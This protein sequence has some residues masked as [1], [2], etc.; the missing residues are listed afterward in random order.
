MADVDSLSIEIEANAKQAA[1]NLD[2]LT[3]SVK[4][5]SNAMSGNSLNNLDKLSSSL[6]SISAIGNNLNG[7]KNFANAMNRLAKSTKDIDTTGLGKMMS[8]VDKLGNSLSKVNVSGAARL[9]GALARLG[10]AGEKVELTNKS[11]PQLTNTIKNFATAMARTEQIS[12]EVVQLTSALAKLASAGA[13]AQQ[14]AASLDTLGKEVESVI[15]RLSKAPQVSANTSQ[16][17]YGLGNLASAGASGRKAL[18][19]LYGSSGRSSSMLSKLGNIARGTGKAISGMGRQTSLSNKGILGMANSIAMLAGRYW[20]LIAGLRKGAQAIGSAM[21]YVETLNYF[22]NTLDTMGNRANEKWKEIGFSS[23]EEYASS[24]RDRAETLLGKMSGFKIGDSG[25]LEM[26]GMQN[27]GVDPDQLMNYSSVFS[28]MANSLGLATTNASKLGQVLPEIGADMASLYNKDFTEVWDDLQSGITG[29]ARTWDKY[30]TN[31]RVA[32]MEQYAATNGLNVNVKTMS[33][34]DKVLLRTIMLLDSQR[35]AWTDLAKT[36]NQPRNQLRMLQASFTNLA[37]SIGSIFMPIV[38]AVLPYLNAIMIVLNKAANAVAN[39]VSALTGYKPSDLT[40]NVAKDTGIADLTDNTEDYTKATKKAT[41]ASKEWKNQLMG[42]DEIDKLDDSSGGDDGG[43]GGN[44]PSGGGGGGLQDAFNGILEE[45]QKAWDKAYGSMSNKAQQMAQTI[46]SL[47]RDAW[48]HNDGSRLGKMIADWLNKGI[49][50]AIGIVEKKNTILKRLAETLGTGLNAL[51]SNLNWEGLGTLIGTSVKGQ[52]EAVKTFLVTVD[53]KNA[54]NAIAKTLNGFIKSKALSTAMST[55]GQGL[56]SAIQLALGA[57]TNFDFKGLGKEL[58]EGISNFFNNMNKVDKSTGMSGWQELG[59][60]ITEGIKGIATALTTAL[61]SVDWD[62]VGQGI[63]DFLKELDW[64]TILTSVAKAIKTALEALLKTYLASFKA[65]PL[66]TAIATG[67]GVL[68][69]TKLGGKLAKKIISAIGGKFSAAKEALST[70]GSKLL[71]SVGN[72]VKGLSVV[73]KIGESLKTFGGKIMAGIGSKISSATTALSKLGTKIAGGVKSALS[74]GSTALSKM[75]TAFTTFAGTIFGQVT[76]C[77][78]AA[79]G[80]WTLGNYLYENNVFG[81]QEKADSIVEKS[82][83]GDLAV[84]VADF[85]QFEFPDYAAKAKLWMQKIV[86]GLIDVTMPSWLKKL[87]G[88][89]DEEIKAFQADIDVKLNGTDDAKDTLDDTANPEGKAR[90]ADIDAKANTKDAEDA[91]GTKGNGSQKGLTRDR[92]VKV[93]P[94]LT[95]SSLD[96]SVKPKLAN[97]MKK[98]SEGW[99]KDLNSTTLTKKVTVGIDSTK[100]KFVLKMN[101][102]TSSSNYGYTWIEAVRKAMGGVYKNGSW[103][104]IQKYASGGLPNQGQMFIAREAGAELVGRLGNSTAVMN[105]DQIVASVAKGVQSAVEVGMRNAIG[106]TSG[107]N[108]PQYV[109][110]DISIDGRKVMESVLAQA[111]TVSLEN[112]GANVFM[113]I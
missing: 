103:Q 72:K 30:G 68:K 8:T 1:R 67:L 5:L 85:F 112:N 60:T 95:K 111:R 13:K 86:A 88:I 23:A 7:V 79:I 28:Q 78:G 59:K 56:R 94:K 37:R 83:L 87:L 45:Y 108:T 63:G 39:F 46:E 44:T 33:Q 4:G 22:N 42:F 77:L 15:T 24:F 82:G 43:G 51:V 47:F 100:K 27:L 92:T 113:S 110:A 35:N 84:K 10:N 93:K 62:S 6:Q 14:S 61:E 11:L 57:V 2:A 81:V 32:N 25:N 70:L 109:Q 34:A 9:T 98:L 48:L 71:T 26:T 75:T 76:L 20:V 66:E 106:A 89:T 18:D 29:M 12:V 55:F 102:D 40:G 36:I 52:F 3:K 64:E 74:F 16:L 97:T 90:K 17:V 38:A 73:S 101:A 49:E 21:D 107:R 53:W 19:S 58:G 96:V 31:I 104:P 69:F 99:Q 91:L 80:G 41:K 50:V 54:G 105:N 65:A